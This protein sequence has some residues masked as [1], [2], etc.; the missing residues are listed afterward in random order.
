[1]ALSALMFLSPIF[2]P[3]EA[4]PTAVALAVGQSAGLGDDGYARCPAGRALAGL[5]NL[6]AAAGSVFA[7]GVGRGGVFRRVRVGFA[8]VL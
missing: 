3:V 2:F 5:G 4:L 1:M 6:G 7:A 8:D